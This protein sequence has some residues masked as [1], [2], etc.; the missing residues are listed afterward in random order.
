MTESS[1]D[2]TVER[3]DEQPPEGLAKL[4]KLVELVQVSIQQLLDDW[5]MF[6]FKPLIPESEG[7]YRLEHRSGTYE[8]MPRIPTGYCCP[9]SMNGMWMNLP[10]RYR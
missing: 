9:V 6:T 8:I 10:S 2:V 1:T 5:R 3:T 7:D 4:G